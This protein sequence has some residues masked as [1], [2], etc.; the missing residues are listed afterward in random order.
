MPEINEAAL[1]KLRSG[2]E[3][4][5]RDTCTV[6]ADSGIPHVAELAQDLLSLLPRRDT[7]G[8]A[9]YDSLDLECRSC[10]RAWTVTLPPPRISTQSFLRILK[11]NKI[12]PYCESDKTV[13][14]SGDG[15]LKLEGP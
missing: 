4:I 7:R 3:K 5:L 12:C 1:E 10:K 13:L 15:T 6:G 9:H 11:A 2:L 14:L 8:A